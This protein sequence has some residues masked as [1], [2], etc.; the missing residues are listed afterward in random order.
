MGRSLTSSKLAMA[1]LAAA[2]GPVTTAAFAGP[3]YNVDGNPFPFSAPPTTM[4]APSSVD[5]GSQAYPSSGPSRIMPRIEG[6]MMPTYGSEGIV[7][8]T[9][10]APPGF[11]NGTPAS[12]QDLSLDQYRRKEIAEHTVSAQTVRR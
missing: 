1:V 9:N 3:P 7:Q 10:S 2:I 6:Q 8:S 4:T 12:A 11:D 5:T